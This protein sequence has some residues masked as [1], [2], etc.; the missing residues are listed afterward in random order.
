MQLNESPLLMGEGILEKVQVG[1]VDLTH[2][3]SSQGHFIFVVKFAILTLKKISKLP[4]VD[5][6]A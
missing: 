5:I 1:L 4:Q 3:D 2:Y 6:N